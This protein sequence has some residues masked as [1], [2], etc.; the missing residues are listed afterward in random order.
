MVGFPVPNRSTLPGSGSVRLTSV[1]VHL[2]QGLT[3]PSSSQ[4]RVPNLPLVTEQHYSR[5]FHEVEVERAGKGLLVERAGKPH[6]FGWSL[7]QTISDLMHIIFPL[8]FGVFFAT[9]F[10]RAIFSH[11]GEVWTNSRTFLAQIWSDRPTSIHV[12]RFLLW[13]DFNYAC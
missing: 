5:L 1:Q 3:F 11:N 10:L 7:S 6:S 13:W 4:C 12:C 8:R 2:C 9:L